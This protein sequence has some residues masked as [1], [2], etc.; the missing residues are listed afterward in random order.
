MRETLKQQRST[1]HAASRGERD[2]QLY[3]QLA[4]V[5]SHFG[6]FDT[7]RSITSVVRARL[8]CAPRR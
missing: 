5:Q 6:R 7:I 1:P 3:G 8:F 4:A 2:I